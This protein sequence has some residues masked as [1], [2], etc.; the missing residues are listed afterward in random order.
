MNF[1]YYLPSEMNSFEIFLYRFFCCISFCYSF[2]GR[3][4][5][6]TDKANFIFLGN[7]ILRKSK[8][9]LYSRAFPNSQSILTNDIVKI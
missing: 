4:Y 8:W 5:E 2:Y 9:M 3:G 7:E 6:L 1:Y